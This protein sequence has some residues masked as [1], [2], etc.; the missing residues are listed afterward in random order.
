MKKARIKQAARRYRDFHEQD[1]DR[2]DTVNFPA[3]DVVM[4]IGELTHIGYLAND[5]KNY[6]HKFRR[7]SRPI[8]AVSADGKQL[9]V[10]QGAYIFND[11]GIVDR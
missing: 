5:G 11:R 4:Q 7:A 1:P 2:I 9:Y 6:L 3:H 8:L 10:L